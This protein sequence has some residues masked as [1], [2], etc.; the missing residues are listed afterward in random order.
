MNDAKRTEKENNIIDAAKR[1]FEN[2]GFRNA[3]MEDIAAEAGIT[4]VTLYSYFKS[5]ENLYLAIT[6]MGLNELNDLFYG[7]LDRNKN[8]PG[9]ESVIEI[10]QSFIK[11]CEENYLY[12]ESLLDYYAIVR[13][14]N[15]GK[16]KDKLTEATKESMYFMKLQDVQNLPFKLTAKEIHRGQV[17]GSIKKELDPMVSTLF[18]WST[19]IGYLKLFASAGKG[20]TPLFHVD[21]KSLHD[22]HLQTV[23]DA[24]APRA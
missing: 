3:K 4:K 2:V 15:D 19:I 17:D 23:R 5:K 11:F 13:S 6:Y 22:L 20:S 7:I 12:S 21:L 16:N 1:V 10:L 24:L 9:I 14:S 18:G 8:K